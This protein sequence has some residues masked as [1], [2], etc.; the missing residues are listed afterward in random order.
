MEKLSDK[1]KYQLNIIESPPQIINKSEVFY[2]KSPRVTS[3][4][5][6]M[7]FF[8]RN[9]IK[10]KDSPTVYDQDRRC[11]IERLIS[12]KLIIA[13]SF[14]ELISDPLISKLL[15]QGNIK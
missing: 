5:K 9:P 4:N 2:I 6:T 1:P 13:P 8:S 15:V 11:K 14:E 7:N 12:E 10:N 3:K